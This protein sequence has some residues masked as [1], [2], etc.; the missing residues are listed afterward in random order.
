MENE[1]TQGSMGST[2]G[3]MGAAQGSIGATQGGMEPI[4]EGNMTKSKK[5]EKNEK[6][7][8]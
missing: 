3:G 2:Q 1:N 8:L 7:T 4:P 5:N 6:C